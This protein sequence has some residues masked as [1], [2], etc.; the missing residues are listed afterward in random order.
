VALDE[1]VTKGIRPPDSRYPRVSDDTLV[2][3]DQASTGFPNIPGVVYA[4]L[5]NASGVRDFGPGVIEN[6]GLVT[7]NPPVVVPEGEHIILVPRVDADGNDVAGVRVPQLEVPIATYT[8]WNVRAAGFSE[9][10]L[11]DLTGM[12]LP[13]ATTKAERMATG[14]PRLSL[15]ERYKNHGG[16]V[17][18]NEQAARKLKDERFLLQEDF[19][20]IV[21][22]AAKSD[23]LK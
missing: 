1:W 3:F 22:E 17:K 10:D 23:V 15:E 2:P 21:S 16:Y 7:L 14:D 20:R 4:G 18:Q 12:F 9:G 5:V 13:F 8:G 19:N 11:C 6:R